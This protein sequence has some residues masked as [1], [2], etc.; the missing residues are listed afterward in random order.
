MAREGRARVMARSA[1]AVCVTP[2]LVLHEVPFWPFCQK[3]TATTPTI[4]RSSGTPMAGCSTVSSSRKLRRSMAQ[5]QSP[6]PPP[7]RLPPP[8][9]PPPRLPPRLPP[10][11]DWPPPGRAA[12]ETARRITET[13]R[14]T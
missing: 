13:A 11:N 12:T 1:A 5:L 10:P 4:T 8:K 3:A 7:P 6:L 9:L 2:G 14:R